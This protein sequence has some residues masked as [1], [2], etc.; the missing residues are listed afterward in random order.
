MY[1]DVQMYSGT[2]FH[3]S[4]QHFFPTQLSRLNM[5]LPNVAVADEFG[6]G[7]DVPAVYPDNTRADASAVSW[8]AVVAGAAA[9]AALSLI[10]LMLGI[11]LGL[12]SLLPWAH[13]GLNGG[14]LG[15]SAFLWVTFKAVMFG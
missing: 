15:V 9:A 6:R 10:M 13:H 3:N 1:A 5:A 4:F 14:T 2:S 11:G 12:S 8:G 7:R